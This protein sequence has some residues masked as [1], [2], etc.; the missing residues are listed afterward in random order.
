MKKTVDC[1]YVL[2][3]KNGYFAGFGYV[4]NKRIVRTSKHY[5]LDVIF[6]ENKVNVNTYKNCYPDYLKDFK[7]V[8]IEKT[9]T[10]EC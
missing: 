10:V 4:T 3:S 7:V 1:F 9:V 2:E 6:H 5:S 8:K